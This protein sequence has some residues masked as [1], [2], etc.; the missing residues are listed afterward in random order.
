MKR[1]WNKVME[2]VDYDLFKPL[3]HVWAKTEIILR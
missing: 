2:Y 1:K 3:E